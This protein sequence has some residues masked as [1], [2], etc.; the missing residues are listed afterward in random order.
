MSSRLTQII[1]LAG[2]ALFFIFLLLPVEGI[3]RLRQFLNPSLSWLIYCG[4]FFCVLMLIVTISDKFSTISAA[5]PLALLIQALIFLLP[6]IYFPLAASSSLST[7]AFSNRFTGL[8]D[9]L[10]QDTEIKSDKTA[11]NDLFQEL[12]AMGEENSRKQA[13]EPARPTL[14]QL[15]NNPGKYQGRMVEVSGMVN[16]QSSFP[17]ETFFVYRFFINCC[18][19]DALPVGVLVSFK[20]SEALES[21]K[22]VRVLGQIRTNRDNGKTLFY[23]AADRV[24]NM[25]KPKMEYIFF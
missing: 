18:A 6:M 2:W 22:W 10:P 1:V 24:D 7:D 11:D 19:A 9:N 14:R 12:L 21:G 3:P 15:M 13:S 25:T 5:R 8:L 17:T 4:L 16:R 23:L 20:Q